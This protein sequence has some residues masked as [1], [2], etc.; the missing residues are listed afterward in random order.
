MVRVSSH[1]DASRRSLGSVAGHL[2]LSV[3]GRR[4]AIFQIR[5]APFLTGLRLQWLELQKQAA[6]GEMA[7]VVQLLGTVDDLVAPEDNLDL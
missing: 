3:T 7:I 6:K 2:M 1:G 4:L 5:R